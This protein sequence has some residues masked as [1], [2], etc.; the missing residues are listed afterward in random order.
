MTRT[1]LITGG[2]QGI[3][4]GIADRLVENDWKVAIF[5]KDAE[6]VDEVSDTLP[7]SLA[8]PVDVADEASV[9]QGFATLADWLAG[10][11]LDL[12]VSNAGIADPVSGPVEDPSLSEWREW[13]DSHLTGAFLC[14]R[15]AVPLLRRARGSIVTIASTRALQSEPD[16]EAYAAAKGG[17]CALTH[18]LAISLGPQIRANCILPGWIETGPWQKRSERSDPDHSRSD[19]AQHPV[20][21]VGTPQDIAALVAYLASSE[22]AG[23]V[24]GQ[25]FVVDGGMTRKMIYLE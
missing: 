16:C 13:Q 22:E 11:G 17:L 20:G 3:G 4:R 10:A 18:A 1:A 23:F 5:D 25:H 6:A 19:K 14:I 8:L 2:A 9:H 12:L 24:T 21:R 15:G 7:G